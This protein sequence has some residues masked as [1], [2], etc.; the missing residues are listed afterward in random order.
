MAIFG[1]VANRL[2]LVLTDDENIIQ[3]LRTLP[4]P[5]K[6]DHIG[7][8]WTL[9]TSDGTAVNSKKESYSNFWKGDYAMMTK[10]LLDRD[11]EILF[12]NSNINEVWKKLTDWIW[13]L[14]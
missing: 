6:S 1:N 13:N 4:P 8:T 7:L 2:D 11:W 10:R 9:L 3:D 14:C 5:G 12:E